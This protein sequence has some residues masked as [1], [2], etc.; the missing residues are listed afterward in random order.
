MPRLRTTNKVSDP[1]FNMAGKVALITGGA[2]GIGASIAETFIAKGARVGLVDVNG[3]AAER[4]TAALGDA[5]R[6]FRCDV[7]QPA[8]VTATVDAALDAFGRIHV[9]VNSAGVV[10]LERAEDLSAESWETT[11]SVNLTGTF[12]VCQAVGRHMLQAGGGKI[13]NLASQAASVA[14]DEHA[15]YCA[16]KAGVIGLTK[17]LASEW[18][19]RGITVNTISPTV[20]LTELGKKAWAGPKGDAFRALIPTGRFAEPE[21]IAAAALFLASDNADMVNGADLR[22]DGGYTVR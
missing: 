7:T 2:A 19:G 16:S 3:E 20:V 6:S 18:G 14:L 17:V 22:I 5:A 10:M 13:I 21:E 1:S 15:A 9:L 11:L 12:L 4:R 8:A